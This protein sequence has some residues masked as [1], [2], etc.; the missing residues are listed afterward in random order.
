[1]S[2]PLASEEALLLYLPPLRVDVDRETCADI[3]HLGGELSPPRIGGMKES[4]T[5]AVGRDEV[6][7]GEFLAQPIQGLRRLSR[8]VVDTLANV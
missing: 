5:I 2:L 3:R 8:L 6:P 7:G 4:G 1:M